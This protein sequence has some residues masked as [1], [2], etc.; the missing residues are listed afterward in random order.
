MSEVSTLGI[1]GDPVS[2]SI[3][4]AMH[5]AALRALAIEATYGRWPTPAAQLPARVAAL[6][7][8]GMVGANVTLPHKVAV[9]PLL[10]RCAA[11]ATYFGAV[12]TIVREPDGSLTGY[13]TDA[14]A[15]R[16]SLLAL[17]LLLPESQAV[18]LGAGGA[19]RAALWA[20]REVGCP[21]ITV[22]NRT[23]DNASRLVRPGEAALAAADPQAAAA[24]SAATLLINTTSLGWQPGDAAPTDLALLHP[25]LFVYDMVYR[26]TPLLQAARSCGARAA[27]GLDMLVRQAGLAFEL[28][29][30]QP[31]PLEI[32]R[33]AA[34]AALRS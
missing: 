26:P 20:L 33:A 9:A 29:F 4:P 3:S 7:S 12:N 14:P 34:E 23:L 1:I 27:D 16:D 22:I 32:M 31:A 17:G 30:R 25:G 5:N 28:W 10:D 19:A 24:I 18:V 15:F 21:G 8:P 11:I 6:R 13:N 2:H